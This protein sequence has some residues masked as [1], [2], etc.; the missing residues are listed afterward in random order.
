[1]TQRTDRVLSVTFVISSLQYNYITDRT[2]SSVYQCSSYP[3][4]PP[5]A[6]P[7]T[8]ENGS[9]RSGRGGGWRGAVSNAAAPEG[10][11]WRVCVSTAH[12]L[13]L[14]A[15]R[16]RACVCVSFFRR[17][18]DLNTP[19]V[20]ICKIVRTYGPWGVFPSTRRRPL[21]CVLINVTRSNPIL[22][23]I[24]GRAALCWLAG[25]PTFKT[26]D[27]YNFHRTYTAGCIFIRRRRRRRLPFCSVLP[28]FLVRVCVF[29]CI[30]F[31]FSARGARK[32]HTHAHARK[33]AY[34]KS[35]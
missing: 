15:V 27:N 26:I 31:A 35:G 28:V 2:Y 5:R 33:R 3:R 21:R 30:K 32:Q 25:P 24:Y 16:K 13:S 8:I 10:G 19:G 34:N 1:M 18:V 12:I 17:R 9:A 4:Y 7:Y 29:V 11:F 14:V 22:M 20:C 6:H 23:E